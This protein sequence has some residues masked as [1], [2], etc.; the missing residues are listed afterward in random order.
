MMRVRIAGNNWTKVQLKGSSQAFHDAPCDEILLEKR[1]RR[2][3]KPLAKTLNVLPV[4]FPFAAQHFGNDAAR[5]KHVRQI[6][7]LQSVLVHQESQNVY[8]FCAR[9]FVALGFE[10]FDQQGQKLGKFFFSASQRAL[11]WSSS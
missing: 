4:Q 10:V 2:N 3:M 6:L 11:R 7:L 8:R 5:S 1:F 9:Q